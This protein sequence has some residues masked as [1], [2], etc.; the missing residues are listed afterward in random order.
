MRG[1]LA[2]GERDILCGEDVAKE[3]LFD[4]RVVFACFDVGNTLKTSCRKEMVRFVA[5]GAQVAL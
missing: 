3:D 1:F 2:K 5:R 4:V